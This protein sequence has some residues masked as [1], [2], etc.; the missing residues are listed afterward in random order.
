MG[1][2][3]LTFYKKNAL[4]GCNYNIEQN[5]VLMKVKKREH[6]TYKLRDA[7]HFASVKGFKQQLLDKSHASE[8][9]YCKVLVS[10][11]VFVLLFSAAKGKCK[12]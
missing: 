4:H 10:R 3:I 2:M 12:Y 11:P 6:D 8:D 9:Y 5:G 1:T 7:P